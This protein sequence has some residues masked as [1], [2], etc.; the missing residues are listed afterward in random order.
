MPVILQLMPNCN[1]T[2]G[3]KET[4][5]LREIGLKILTNHVEPTKNYSKVE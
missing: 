5:Y 4:D 1:N 2:Q 3:N